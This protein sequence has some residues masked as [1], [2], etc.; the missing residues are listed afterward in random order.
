MRSPLLS[1]GHGAVS[2]AYVVRSAKRQAPRPDDRKRRRAASVIAQR[3]QL[4]KLL[5]G[6]L[7]AGLCRSEARSTPLAVALH[8]CP[9]ALE[10]LS[11]S[12]PQGALSVAD[13]LSYREFASEIR[14]WAFDGSASIRFALVLALPVGSWL[15]GAVVERIVE[16]SLR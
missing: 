2:T 12:P 16:A 14:E 9:H 10:R 4:T 15:G 7:E 5:F 6:E 1:L 11:I 3:F 8:Q 13:L